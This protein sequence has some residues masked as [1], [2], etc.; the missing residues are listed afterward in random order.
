[1]QNNKYDFIIW[2]WNGTLFNDVRLCVDIM[3]EILQKR[4]LQALSLKKYREI[5]DFPVKDYYRKLGFDFEKEPFENLGVEFIN[6]YNRL[7]FKASLHKDVKNILQQLYLNNKQQYVLSAREHKALLEDLNYFGISDCINDVSG[8]NNHLAKGKLQL[9][10][11]LIKKHNIDTRKCVLIG[12]T[13]HDAEVAE[14][15][16]LDCV[17]IAGGHHSKE[18]LL[19]AGVLVIDEISELFLV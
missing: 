14:K 2:D 10:E 8:L 6:E 13:L 18:R 5:F 1:M 7:R 9:G 15:L 4:N 19:T 12:D 16:K 11:N 17:L 3:N